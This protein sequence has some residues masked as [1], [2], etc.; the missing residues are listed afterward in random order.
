MDGHGQA[1]TNM[2]RLVRK[3]GI[4]QDAPS[5]SGGETC[6]VR[7]PQYRGTESCV[8]GSGGETCRVRPRAT[9]SSGQDT[10]ARFASG[11]LVM[12]QG[13]SYGGYEGPSSQGLVP[14]PG[15]KYQIHGGYEGPSAQGFVV[16]SSECVLCWR[17]KVGRWRGGVRDGEW[18]L[19]AAFAVCQCLN[20]SRGS[21]S[22]APSSNRTCGFPAYGFRSSRSF[23]GVRGVSG[24]CPRQ[25]VQ[26]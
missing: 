14:A 8:G 18:L 11:R 13:P 7:P 16:A 6:R 24:A 9:A 22:S 15:F 19:L 5:G 17:G 4:S 10:P 12:G 23:S 1:W 21:V 2:D 25:S 20:P 3:Y 26:S